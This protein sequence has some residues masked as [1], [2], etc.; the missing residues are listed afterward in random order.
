VQKNKNQKLTLTFRDT[1]TK[2][3]HQK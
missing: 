2:E 3:L 1:K